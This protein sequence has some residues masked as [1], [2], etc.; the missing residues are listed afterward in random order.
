MLFSSL[1]PS[2]SGAPKTH[3]PFSQRTS[4]PPSCESSSRLS[5]SNHLPSANLPESERND[6]AQKAYWLEPATGTNHVCERTPSSRE[7]AKVQSFPFSPKSLTQQQEQH[8]SSSLSTTHGLVFHKSY[9]NFSSLH[10][11]PSCT[12]SS[13]ICKEAETHSHSRSHSSS[14][15]PHTSSSSPEAQAVS[16]TH[17]SPLTLYG[18]V[19][20][21]L[22]S[23]G[24]LSFRGV[25]RF[26]SH[27]LA[28]LF[29]N[30]LI[31]LLHFQRKV[32]LSAYCDPTQRFT[33][34]LSNGRYKA[35]RHCVVTADGY[36]I[37][38][39]RLVKVTHSCCANHS[40]SLSRISSSSSPSLP[41]IIPP[42][43]HLSFSSSSP[44]EHTSALL[45]SSPSGPGFNSC[46]HHQQHSSRRQRDT[47]RHGYFTSSFTPSL[48]TGR[49]SHPLVSSTSSS[50]SVRFC[51]CERLPH[52]D[53]RY[54][55]SYK[56]P[57]GS[58][59]PQQLIPSKGRSEPHLPVF[60][61]PSIPP[62]PGEGEGDEV[63]DVELDDNDSHEADDERETLSPSS[64]SLPNKFGES[65]RTK[66]T[67][68]TIEEANHPL[69]RNSKS[70][71]G[72]SQRTLASSSFHL[73]DHH[74][75]SSF[76]EGRGKEKTG[77]SSPLSHHEEERSQ[78]GEAT[79]EARRLGAREEMRDYLHHYDGEERRCE[80]SHNKTVKEE[81]EKREKPI[82]FFQHGLLESSLNWITGG[83]HSLAFMLAEEGCD[84]WLGNNRG[85]E[86]VRRRS[87][88]SSSSLSSKSTCRRSMTSSSSSPPS[89]IEP[90]KRKQDSQE[91]TAS[92]LT[93]SKDRHC[94]GGG[95]RFTST[96][97]H[98]NEDPPHHQ[99][100][101]NR[102]EE[103]EGHCRNRRRRKGV[104]GMTL[105]EALKEY[106]EEEERREDDEEAREKGR[107]MREVPTTHDLDGNRD[108]PCSS[109]REEGEEKKDMSLSFSSSSCSELCCS[110]TGLTPLPSMVSLFDASSPS[111][112]SPFRSREVKT[113]ATTTTSP[114]DLH[115]DHE[116]KVEG[117]LC[118]HSEKD[119]DQ[120]HQDENSLVYILWNACL[121]AA[122]VLFRLTTRC[123]PSRF[124]S[125]MK[126]RISP[127]LSLSSSPSRG[128]TVSSRN[129]L[130]PQRWSVLR[131][132]S[133]DAASSSLKGTATTSLPSFEKEEKTRRSLS[134]ERTNVV[135]S[136]SFHQEV[137][138]EEGANSIARMEEDNRRSSEDYDREEEMRKCQDLPPFRSITSAST[139]SW[140]F[141][142]M[143][144][145][146]VSAM[147]Y[148]ILTYSDDEEDSEDS[149]LSFS[150]SS[151]SSSLSQNHNH[152]K[153]NSTSVHQGDNFLPRHEDPPQ[154]PSSVSCSS[155]SFPPH[156][157]SSSDPLFSSS[158]PPQ[159]Y[160][161]FSSSS[162]SGSQR[163]RD[164]ENTERL[165]RRRRRREGRK[166][167]IWGIG[168]SQGAAQL[169]A[170]TSIFPGTGDLFHGLLLFSPP[171][172]LHS[173]STLSISTRALI[174]LGL[175]HPSPVLHG[176]KLAECLLP[177]VCL[178]ILADCV[179]GRKL[180]GFYTGD[181]EW[182]QRCINFRYTPSGGTSRR[183]FQHWL[184]VMGKGEPIGKYEDD[185]GEEGEEI[186]EET[187]EENDEDGD[188]EEN[189]DQRDNGRC[190]RRE[191][192]KRRRIRREEDQ[193]EFEQKQKAEKV[194][195]EM[196]EDLKS[197]DER[198]K[199]KEGQGGRRG[200]PG[201]GASYPLEKITCRVHAWI[202]GKDNLV[203]AGSCVVKKGGKNKVRCYHVDS[204]IFT[205]AT[206]GYMKRCI[207][208][209]TVE[210]WPEAGH[211]DFGWTH[212]RSVDLYPRLIRLILSS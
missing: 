168:Q 101:S 204:V 79:N 202:G 90:P 30:L 75:A 191:M 24:F 44:K 27:C 196:G 59:R 104:C 121:E 77:V 212:A 119:V 74:I 143:A 13:S 171:V 141:H 163:W 107:A 12:T 148:Y 40:F 156:F 169:L 50:S 209:L 57:A 15:H 106:E 51:A 210:L 14:L 83:S 91:T 53:S 31:R 98:T 167:K 16:F 153:R 189:R 135:S 2:D 18:Y 82:V 160:A 116:R 46:H 170:L 85:N 43:R 112:S 198:A 23:L 200:I 194:L 47:P 144:K 8:R 11:Y 39:Y 60:L 205:E 137:V 165:R 100:S 67:P 150:S 131:H 128:T 145:Y 26:V 118:T 19:S 111:S 132:P 140:T 184:N 207:K 190:K 195:K 17:Y 5:E 208:D 161:D 157:S 84:V 80:R 197:G 110:C 3:Q 33:Y 146:D 176:I 58:E 102:N 42:S 147:L 9:H 69:S 192:E 114:S 35:E 177:E 127:S 179:A 122:A 20:S 115:Y 32:Y 37:F 199:G 182:G 6:S 117:S 129:P 63:D 174:H 158:R 211:L 142:D 183:N 155:S 173:P 113:T 178:S 149:H 38:F 87:A 126:R 70:S 175:T 181:I 4:P 45:S 76:V 124:L 162:S 138:D 36:E 172:I 136:P 123:H 10:H 73:S 48:T 56:F 109:H 180:M 206:T 61:T 22:A 103:R 72:S 41:L 188:N 88:S 25:S 164:R 62:H 105:V 29:R 139:Q 81:T 92:T 54:S 64:L 97:D 108:M 68:I 134:S 185:D 166:K 65:L 130:L 66:N 86:Y 78:H 34:L 94:A 159:T 96:T 154:N 186:N 71:N 1:I 203:N 21:V 95:R 120:D 151:F 89:S 7:N 133:Q 52:V 187:Y 152:S 55:S 28:L 193:A 99:K 125:R 93:S 49:P 201:P